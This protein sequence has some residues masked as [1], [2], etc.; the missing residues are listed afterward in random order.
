MQ[1]WF[2]FFQATA[3][4]C[5]T[6]IGMLVVAISINLSRILSIAHLPGR[7]AGALVPLSGALVVSILAFVP[8]QPSA[9]FGAEVLAAGVV[10]WLMS[11]LLVL[12]S[13]SPTAGMPVGRIWS[14]VALGQ[15][16]SLPFVA[17]GV[18]LILGVPRGLYWIAPGMVFAILGGILNT[19]VLLV[20]ILR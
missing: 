12:R 20:E 7:A 10:I 19:W 16:Q 17:T 11:G 8:A 4:A 3:G 14:H 6:L 2:G 5:A 1:N 15:A 9:A 13:L 18:L